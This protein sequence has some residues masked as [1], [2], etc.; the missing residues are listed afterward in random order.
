MYK[1]Q[2]FEKI[3][4][5]V[6]GNFENRY[7]NEKVFVTGTGSASV[8]KRVVEE[9]NKHSKTIQYVQCGRNTEI[10]EANLKV[11]LV[12]NFGKSM[13]YEVERE[14]EVWAERNAVLCGL[15]GLE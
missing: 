5:N 3:A 9:L 10:K 13:K 6:S 11:L 4:K 12:E 8:V 15:I 14:I 7:E 2:G 1:R